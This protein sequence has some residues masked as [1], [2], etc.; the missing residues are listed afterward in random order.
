MFR[1]PS[2][3]DMFWRRLGYL[4]ALAGCL[5]FYWAYREWLSGLLLA[6]TLALP[7][8]SLLVSLPSMLTAALELRC[9]DG[10]QT[11]EECP[12]QWHV[13]CVHPV[14][15]V[16]GWVQRRNLQTGKLTRMRR[17]QALEELHC[18]G[19]ELMPRRVWVQDYFGL[20]SLPVW[21][22]QGKT[23][24]I[25]PV[26]VAMENP[27]DVLRYRASAFR[28]K[29]GGGFAEQHELRLYRPGDQ[30]R[31]VHWKLS[32]KSS[33]LVIR[34][35]MEPIRG[36]ALVTLV[37]RGSPQVLD[38]K[39]G[40]LHWLSLWLLEQE[41]PHTVQSLTGSGIQTWEVGC[42]EDAQRAVDGLLLCPLA[43]PGGS[44]VFGPSSWHCHIGGDG[45]E[46]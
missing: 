32:A 2:C 16:R 46:G 22:K 31:Q 25:R 18:G 43:E 24:V 40:K 29:A 7:W 21:K 12:V 37:L 4:L 23:V 35:P 28:P 34:E 20:F 8:F 41:I 11:G 15:E 38:E 39:L 30:L 10:V 42:P 6:F 9:P 19:W 3:A 36:K 17:G 27:P 45:D 13:R 1:H 14:A 33:K 5:V 26:K 44:P